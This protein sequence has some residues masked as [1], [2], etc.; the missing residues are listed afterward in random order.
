MMR[1]LYL[2][3]FLSLCIV[4]ILSLTQEAYAIGNDTTNVTAPLESFA[5]PSAPIDLHGIW[6]V[7]LADIEIIMAVSQSGDALFGLCKSEGETPSNGAI[8]GFVLER[9]TDV[10]MAF[11]EE[12]SLSAIQMDGIAIGDT[13]S[14]NYI[15]SDEKGNAAKGNFT[16]IRISTEIS[17]Y[18]PVKVGSKDLANSKPQPIQPSTEKHLFQDVNNLAKG[19]N[20]TIMPQHTPLS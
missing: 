12:K 11:I 9:E 2:A 15:G 4:S 7:S 19:I 17:D 6:R 14:G 10:A 13:M 3:F 16:A 5:E 1:S 18:S 20:P 8:A